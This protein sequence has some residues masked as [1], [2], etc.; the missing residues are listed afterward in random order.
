[1]KKLDKGTP[2]K[3]ENLLVK[4]GTAVLERVATHLAMQRI[5]KRL[6][7]RGSNRRLEETPVIV[8]RD[9]AEE[10]LD[11]D[12]AWEQV[13]AADADWVEIG[14]DEGDVLEH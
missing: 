13:E 14:R 4:G 8:E 2:E 6:A 10:F 5:E 3:G 9:D 11:G 12:D 7:A 1:M